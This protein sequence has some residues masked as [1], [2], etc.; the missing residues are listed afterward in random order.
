MTILK[1]AARETSKVGA[2]G[3]GM[4]TFQLE[5]FQPSRPNY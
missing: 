5:F 3:L 1:T 4:R 2:H